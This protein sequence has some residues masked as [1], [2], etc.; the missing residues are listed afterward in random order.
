HL[1]KFV[2]TCFRGSV[3]RI[4]A[5]VTTSD[6][7]RQRRPYLGLDD[8]VDIIVRPARPTPESAPRLSPSGGIA[9][10][11]HGVTED[12]CGVFRQRATL[13][14]LLIAHLDATEV[15]H[16]ILHGHFHPLT[17]TRAD[18]LV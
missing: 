12:L 15:Q 13:E 14:P 7:R 11:R 3:F 4:I 8:D 18:P 17:S 5:Q 1:V 10:T 2:E 9:S 16:S 6:Q